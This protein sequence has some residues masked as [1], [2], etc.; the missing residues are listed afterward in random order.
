MDG[1]HNKMA[2][3]FISDE[4]MMKLEQSGTVNEQ[5]EDNIIS[6]EEM[7]ELMKA[8][9]KSE[10]GEISG[11]ESF[12]RS[13]GQGLTLGFADEI[14]HY[15][16]GTP[17]EIIRK[18]YAEA[19]QANQAASLAGNLASIVPSL[20]YGGAALRLGAKGA[21]LLAKK[22]LSPKAINRL[23]KAVEVTDDS[24][25]GK[26]LAVGT[27]T[28][29]AAPAAA[30][31]AS[32]S[33]AALGESE[34]QSVEQA[35][36]DMKEGALTGALLGGG[37]GVA[38]AAL[39]GARKLSQAAWDKAELSTL[40]KSTKMPVKEQKEILELARKHD[41]VGFNIET[42]LD[43]TLKLRSNALDDL[44]AVQK[45]VKDIDMPLINKRKMLKGLNEL[46]KDYKFETTKDARKVIDSIIRDVEKT[47]GNVDTDRL[48]KFIG[49]RLGH[50]VKGSPEVKTVYNK[51]Y[52]DMSQNID[53][54]LEEYSKRVQDPTI[55]ELY[56][57]TKDKF[58]VAHKAAKMVDQEAMRVS[59]KS[60]LAPQYGEV[61]KGA[62]WGVPA[63]MFYYG[64]RIG[65]KGLPIMTSKIK[66]QT[67]K[68]KQFVTPSGRQRK[69]KEKNLRETL[70]AL[71]AEQKG[72]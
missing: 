55:R 41:L 18:Q 66:S 33:V 38:G 19:E 61:A 65:A 54:T 16:T 8:G 22:G 51:I 39:K 30:L 32:E 20:L 35:I 2:K 4:E 72:E 60:G 12:G 27:A 53:D 69:S 64:A 21:Q 71:K 37:L 68:I 31:A 34:K 13:L 58:R 1:K 14:E 59:G 28:K 45:K 7:S 6:D 56:K 3:D 43:K 47:Q 57:V 17:I 15:L 11:L 29:V 50:N 40:G 62:L 9:S 52:A 10:P 36:Q 26:K 5:K 24:G 23:K 63:A 49:S 48:Y 46:R 70:D 25:L 44:I 42:T 67:E